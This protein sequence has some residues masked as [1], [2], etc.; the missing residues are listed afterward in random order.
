MEAALDPDLLLAIALSQSLMVPHPF[1][2][3]ATFGL[4]SYCL[5]LNGGFQYSETVTRQEK[6]RLQTPQKKDKRIRIKT[7]QLSH[8]SRYNSLLAWSNFCFVATWENIQCSIYVS[9]HIGMNWPQ[10]CKVMTSYQKIWPLYFRHWCPFSKNPT[11]LQIL[12][13]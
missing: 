12:T 8:Q 13:V 2:S 4:V 7:S 3:F 9:I 5:I 10:P 6:H 1:L 11:K